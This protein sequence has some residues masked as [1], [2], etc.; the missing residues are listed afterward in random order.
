ME[1]CNYLNSICG[2]WSAAF[3]EESIHVDVNSVRFVE[4]LMPESTADKQLIESLMDNGTF[5]PSLGDENIRKSVLQCLLETKGRILSLHSL[6][7]DT[8]FI[9]P[10][11]KALLQLVPPAFLDLRDALMRRLET[12]E[13]AWTIQVSETVAETFTA[14]LDPSSLACDGSICA[15]AFVQLWLFAMR[16]IE[17]LTSATLPGRQKEFCDGNHVYRETRQESAHELAILAQT[18]WF[19]SP[20]IRSLF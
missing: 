2:I 10:C 18:L 1:I 16:Y 12:H 13:A 9:Q 6:V 5:S 19:D 3:E 4:N 17:N 7:Q 15:V 20:Q 14:D 11:A 8:L